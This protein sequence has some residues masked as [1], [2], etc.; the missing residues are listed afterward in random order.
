MA[1]AKAETG[2]GR[3]PNATAP[4]AAAGEAEGR[5][6]RQREIDRARQQATVAELGVKALEGAELGEL[7]DET[8]TRIAEVLEVEMSEVLRRDD[9]LEGLILHAGVGWGPGL[10]RQATAPLSST[11]YTG[12]VW[13]SRTRVA[14]SDFEQETRFS[15]TPLL[16]EHGVVSV[17][18]VH[19]GRRGH[20]FGLLGALSTS[21][22][23]FTEDDLN[24]LTAVANVLAHAI[25]RRNSEERIRHQALHDPLTGLPN[26]TL[27]LD[28]LNHW[29]ERADRSGGRG[30]VLFCD[31]DR[32]KLVNDGLGHDVGDQLLLAVAER[33][34]ASVRPTDTVARVGGDE[35]VLFC[36]DIPSEPAALEV[37]E[38]LMAGLEE[39]FCLDDGERHVTVSVGIALATPGDTAGALL[40]D[41]DA[42]MY[43]AKE[44]GRARF[45]LFDAAMRDRT[46]AWIETERDLRAAIEGGE[47][48][49]VYQPVVSASGRTIG[50]EALVRWSHP[51]RGTISPAEFI[52]VAE[53][54]GLIVPVGRIVLEQACRDAVSWPREEGSDSLSVSVN[55]SP[56]QVADPTLV[57]TVAG[58][59]ERSG[60][61]P[62]RLN[63]EITETVLIEN[64]E[65]ALATLEKLKAL[66]TS[67]VLDDFGTGYS[68]L[69]YVKRFP[70]DVLKIDRSFVDGLGEGGRDSAIVNAVVSMGRALDMQVVAEG[71]ETPEQARRL[72]NM[73]CQL[74]QGF[75]YARPM[76]ADAVPAY[77]AG[78]VAAP[79]LNRA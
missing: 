15:P 46:R 60:L 11:Y 31:L 43:R 9:Q 6:G 72:I 40:R 54:S 37:V 27:L 53:Q 8:A 25:E 33:L 1:G 10:L 56:R 61:A 22:R 57:G 52:P 34:E 41:A 70:I 58:T 39:P 23:E 59:L 7:V 13:S 29:L 19:I 51:Q 36:E 12:F 50:F 62:Q 71:V 2:N 18:T 78:D 44:R 5:D 30:A 4:L 77:L 73:G 49:N 65:L 20:P 69:G 38:R 14:V 66:G 64:T 63:L 79:L 42:A 17:A 35:F 16:Q 32:F 24:F 48:Y 67:I 28:R 74:A 26:R 21:P 75:L 55:L 47:L 45:E 3:G 76:D 68:S